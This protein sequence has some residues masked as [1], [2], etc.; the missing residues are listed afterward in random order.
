MPLWIKFLQPGTQHPDRLPTD[1]QS[2]LMSGTVDS[3]GQ[4]AGNDKTTPGQVSGKGPGG[5]Q[6]RTRCAATADN[7]QLRFLQQRRVTGH[8][9]QGWSAIH[10]SQ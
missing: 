2:S 1:I 9:Q 6:R 7:R 8:E 3:Q 10:F 5:V 4:A